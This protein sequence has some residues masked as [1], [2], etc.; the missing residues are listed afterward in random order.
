MKRFSLLISLI[1]TLFI[2]SST[3]FAQDIVPENFESWIEEGM[4]KWGIPGMAIAIVKDGEIAYSKGFGVKKLGEDG[5][6][7]E[8]TQ[9]GIASV[10]KHITAMSVG[11][12]VEQG[13][14]NWNDPVRDILPW[15]ELSDPFATANVTIHDLLT[16]Q[17]GVGRIL[18]NR[19]QFMTDRSRYE[20]IHRMRHHTFEEPFRSQ[21]V[22]SNVMYTLA[23]EIAAAVSGRDWDD[24]VANRF[25]ERMEMTRTNTSINDLDE[26]NAAWPHQYINGEVVPIQRRN[27]DIA[28]P[29]GGVNSTVS[30]MAKWM[31]M[32]LNEGLYEGNRI[33]SEEVMRD[34]QTPKVSLNSTNANAPQNSYGYGYRITD[35][36]GFRILSH[37]GATDGMNTNY[38]LMPQHNFGIIIM[39]NTFNNFLD[40]VGYQVID[41]MLGAT[42]RDWAELYYESYSNQF[43]TTTELREQFESTRISG[44]VPTHHLQDYVGRYINDL[45]DTAR[46]GLEDDKLILTIFDDEDLTAE[47]EHWHH[48]T[49]R[50]IWNNPAQREEFLQFHM[51]YE[52]KINRL[53]IRFTLRP[54][55]LQVGAYPSNSYR[56]V[57]YEKLK[58]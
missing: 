54:M 31:L 9:F 38:M 37:G 45:Y 19:L 17:V 20:L 50:M 57:V 49:F 34:I 10:S 24:L 1:L 12:M 56:D 7:N 23:G 58:Y 36:R 55:M 29:A 39:T 13:L 48:N 32:Q 18:G 43:E 15:F 35:F 4:E 26:T 2:S 42:D 47:L 21:Y 40:A 27:W 33:L 46:I 8:H 22:Y 30:D 14:I 41:H 51:D 53:E 44:T 11:L 25:F 5:L 52:G 16:H 6:I 3:L 28:A